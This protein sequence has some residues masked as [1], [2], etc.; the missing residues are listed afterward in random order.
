MRTTMMALIAVFALCWSVFSQDTYAAFRPDRIR[1]E[2]LA[3]TNP[4]HQ[5][6][7][8]LLRERRVLERMQRLL[9]FIRLPQPLLLK[10]AGCDGESNA[11]YEESEHAVTVC[12]EYLAD[13]NRNAPKETTAAGVTPQDAITGPVIEVFMHETGHALFNLLHIPV[14]GR[15]EDAADQVAA[16]MML[17]LGEEAAR[18]TIGGVAYMY[19]HE[20][21]SAELKPSSFAKFAN[22]H[23]LDAQRL[24][25]V[26]CLAYGSNSKLFADVVE[27]KY[28]PEARAEGCEDEFKQVQ[29]AISTLFK[30]YID[31]KR[32]QQVRA[33][34]WLAKRAQ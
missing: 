10:T 32:A 21:Q 2:Y 15:E 12:Y 16:Y 23:G 1:I 11:W 31:R 19:Y 6:L 29:Y 28:L 26:L 14:L 22:V 24:Y 20:A 8:E 4:Q 27:K 13:L 18:S 9:S 17:S 5:H 30:P 33:E 25:N 3:P 34:F 7:Y